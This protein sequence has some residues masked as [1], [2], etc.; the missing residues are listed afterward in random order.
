VTV[1]RLVTRG[2]S[3]ERIKEMVAAKMEFADL[4]VAEG[5]QW[6][7]KLSNTEVRELVELSGARSTNA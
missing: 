1:Y 4:T 7:T 2:T 5:E 6:L 3:E